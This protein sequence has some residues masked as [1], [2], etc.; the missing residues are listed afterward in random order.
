MAGYLSDFT[1]WTT[2]LSKMDVLTGVNETPA[3]AAQLSM[4]KA[5]SSGLIRH[6]WR[7]P[8][9]NWKY[10]D[11][12]SFVI[13]EALGEVYKSLIHEIKFWPYPNFLEHSNKFLHSTLSKAFSAFSAMTTSG[14]A[15]DAGEWIIFR[16]WRIFVK[17]LRPRIKPIWSTETTSHIVVSRHKA[18]A[19]ARIFASLFRREIGR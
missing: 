18:R 2:T 13:P 3:A 5:N 15:V 10:C 4:A 12:L 19:L 17:E 14:T 6:P 8:L 7:V 11:C 9:D 16:S 1:T